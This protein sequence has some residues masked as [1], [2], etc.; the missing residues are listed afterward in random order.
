[1][2][3]RAQGKKRR[4]VAR[5]GETVCVHESLSIILSAGVSYFLGLRLSFVCVS[6]SPSCAAKPRS[7]RKWAARQTSGRVKSVP[8]G[9]P[10]AKSNP[11]AFAGKAARHGHS[12]A[13]LASIALVMSPSYCRRIRT[14]APSAATGTSTAARATS[15]PSILSCSGSMEEMTGLVQAHARRRDITVMGTRGC[16]M[17]AK[18]IR[19]LRS[20]IF[21]KVAISSDVSFLLLI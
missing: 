13:P 19:F 21:S 16:K 17:G 5:E 18:Y 2:R 15:S 12:K 4:L 14:V 1:V 7:H 6:V 11:A 9:K 10:L 20:Q 3:A 8:A